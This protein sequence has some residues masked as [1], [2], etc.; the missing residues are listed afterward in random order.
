MNRI[1]IFSHCPSWNLS[2]HGIRL[3]LDVVICV[4]CLFPLKPMGPAKSGDGDKCPGSRG[5]RGN[6][7]PGRQQHS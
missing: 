1:L 5:A 7:G 4:L 2:H 3:L 6:E